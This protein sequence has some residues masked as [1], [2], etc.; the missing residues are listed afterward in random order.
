[1][2]EGTYQITKIESQKRHKGRV[3]IYLDEAFA[4]GLEE[5]VLLKHHLHV[6]DQITQKSIDELLLSEEKSRVKNKAILYLS[7]RS[8]SVAELT[9]KLQENGFKDSIVRKVVH[10][11][12]RVGL[13]DDKVFASSYVQ[14]RMVQKPMAKALLKKELLLKGIEENLAIEAVEEFYGERSEMDV[15]RELIQKK[16]FQHKKEDHKKMR[17][18]MSDFLLRRGFGWDVIASVFGELVSDVE[19]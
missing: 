16:K 13:L 8:R 12:F 6:G 11:L 15:A 14:T 2:E 18:K 4:F 9:K 5:T 17:K 10:D 7:Y 1:M 19:D 3:N